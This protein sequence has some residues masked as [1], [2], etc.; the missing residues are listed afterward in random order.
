MPYIYNIIYITDLLPYIYNIIYITG[1]V[2]DY[3]LYLQYYIYN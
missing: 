2:R 3:A 1:L